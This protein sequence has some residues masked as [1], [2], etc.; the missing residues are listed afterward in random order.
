MK[1]L[2][3]YIKRY[4][5]N[6]ALA[7]I[8][9]ASGYL[10]HKGAAFENAEETTITLWQLAFLA[11]ALIL[12]ANDYK[13]KKFD[14]KALKLCANMYN[15]LHEPLL[16][17]SCDDPF[18]T[19]A[20][21]LRATYKQFPYQEKSWSLVPRTLYLYKY[22]NNVLKT[23]RAFS[24]PKA[25]RDLFQFSIEDL[26]IIGCC[27]AT[28]VR[29]GGYFDPKNII[30]ALPNRFKEHLTEDKV[31]HFLQEI[32]LDYQNF[33]EKALE[34]EKKVPS[35]F[36]KY[37]FNPLCE[38]P[39]IKTDQKRNGKRQY[40]IPIPPLLLRKITDGVY[41]D[42]FA[43]YKDRFSQ[44]FGLVFEEYVGSLLGKFYDKNHLI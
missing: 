5:L 32:V 2:Y 14:E 16:D 11:K 22:L 35:G 7:T 39:I 9:R 24:I 40:V 44:F 1:D 17:A 28:S 18:L 13:S 6:D 37:A 4:K 25:I 42:L 23:K 8:S 12:N 21:Y 34:E 10:L 30:N 19:Q 3:Q 41:Y 31:K 33:R 38:C 20:F 26:L 29:K 43:K 36:V 27:A 15:N